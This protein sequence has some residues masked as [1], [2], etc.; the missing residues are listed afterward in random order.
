V[1]GPVAVAPTE[2]NVMT[3]KD[4]TETAVLDDEIVRE[5]LDGEKTDPGAPSRLVRL[6]RDESSKG[7]D[8]GSEDKD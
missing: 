3:G 5:I 2:E 4:Q 6:K 8:E 1:T 7:E